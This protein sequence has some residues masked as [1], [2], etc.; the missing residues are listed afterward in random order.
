MKVLFILEYFYPYRG[1]AEKL[2]HQL[3]QELS[4]SSIEVTVLTASYDGLP[5]EQTIGTVK[6]LRVKS[7]NRFHFSFAAIRKAKELAKTTDLIHTT[8][9]NAA[10]P[11][12]LASK[13]EA[14]PIFITVHEYW[15]E[16]WWKIP[17]LNPLQRLAFWLYEQFILSLP[18][19]K[20]V[21]VSN[22]TTTRLNERLSGKNVHCIMN[23]QNKITLLRRVVG[24]Y[25]LFVGRL[26][27]SIGIDILVES[28]SL[29][30]NKNKNLRF[31]LV[32][33]QAN[34]RISKYTHAKLS[35][36]I[37]NHQVEL[38]HDI[39]ESDLYKLMAGSKAV[40]VPS[41]S[42]GFGF[43]AS[44]A[45]ALGVPVIHSGK[46][47]LPEA[48]GGRVVQFEPYTSKALFNAIL[49]AEA[50]QFDEIDGKQFSIENTANNYIQQYQDI[51]LNHQ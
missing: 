24:N 50:N 6:I 29:S 10:L 23:G 9:Y 41:F 38:H 27:V 16:I 19:D 18:Y 44:E 37:S 5:L 35:S 42:E 2:F 33:P 36:Y 47:A 31:K 34:D 12:W 49:K 21:G 48:I 17:F 46:G 28:I 1:G 39:D 20:I 14:K 7:R 3:T 15:N 43:V 26:G 32:I 4:K 51:M 30:L 40:I 13:L 8:T 25:Y 11:A 45:A 22:Y